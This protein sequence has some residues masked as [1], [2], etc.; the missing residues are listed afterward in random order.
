MQVIDGGTCYL[1]HGFT[2]AE[3]EDLKVHFDAFCDED[4]EMPN[5][6][7]P[8]TPRASGRVVS[9]NFKNL[10]TGES[11]VVSDMGRGMTS[12]VTLV[13]RALWTRCL[14][15]KVGH[16]C[17]EPEISAPTPGDVDGIE[18]DRKL[19]YNILPFFLSFSLSLIAMA[20]NLR[21][22]AST[23]AFLTSDFGGIVRLAVFAGEGNA[24]HG[25]L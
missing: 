19:I 5:L 3:A 9:A 23:Q 25:G 15:R 4:G 10:E 7:M 20:C 11:L 21:V 14:G 8:G 24:G 12:F 17:E 16:L 1:R 2:R 6:Q 18:S 13:M 22:M